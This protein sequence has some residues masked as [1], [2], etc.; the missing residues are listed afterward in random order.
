MRN[1]NSISEFHSILGKQHGNG[2]YSFLI[3]SQ[4]LGSIVEYYF[5]VKSSDNQL[6]EYLPNDFTINPQKYFSYYVAEIAEELTSKLN[7]EKS[8]ARTG[9]WGFVRD[10]NSNI[11]QSSTENKY[12]PNENSF[13]ET[14]NFIKDVNN[15]KE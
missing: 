9:G 14:Q 10:G 11:I 1:N 3:P 5:E 7:D 4:K 8:W 6:T 2:L 15:L 12:R 13:I